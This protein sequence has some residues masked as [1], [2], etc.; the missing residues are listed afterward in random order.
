MADERGSRVS[1]TTSGER[2]ANIA[3]PAPEASSAAGTTP[4]RSNPVTSLGGSNTAKA[5][6]PDNT[7]DTSEDGM[8]GPPLP[9]GFRSC[10]AADTSPAGTVHAGYRKVQAMSIFGPSCDWEPNK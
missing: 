8:L 1:E 10:V 2:S 4:L 5:G 6:E 9:G 3:A 7:A